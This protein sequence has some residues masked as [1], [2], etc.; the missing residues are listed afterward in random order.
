MALLEDVLSDR[1]G[2]AVMPLPSI[3]MGLG[4]GIGI[5]GLIMIGLIVA[6]VVVLVIMRRTPENEWTYAKI[7]MAGFIFFLIG[8]CLFILGGLLT[9]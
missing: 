2:D 9:L 1:P 6:A 5:T 7:L 8:F 4:A 3:L